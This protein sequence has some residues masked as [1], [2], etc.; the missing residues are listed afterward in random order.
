MLKKMIILITSLFMLTSLFSA[1]PAFA[2]DG[3]IQ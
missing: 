2:N 3:H 1:L